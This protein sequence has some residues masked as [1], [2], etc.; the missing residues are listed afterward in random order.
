MSEVD[1]QICINFCFAPL[2]TSRKYSF[3]FEK[4]CFIATIPGDSYKFGTDSCDDTQRL[5]WIKNRK[6]KMRQSYK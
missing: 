5:I 2:N 3:I 4:S 1:C 6:L